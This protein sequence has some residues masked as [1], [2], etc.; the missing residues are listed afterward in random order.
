MEL[1]TVRKATFNGGA[2]ELTQ[3]VPQVIDQTRA[4]IQYAETMIYISESSLDASASPTALSSSHQHSHETDYVS[5][6]IR[7]DRDLLDLISMLHTLI[8][9]LPSPGLPHLVVESTSRVRKGLKVLAYYAKVG[10]LL[11]L[12]CG[13]R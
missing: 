6:I 10:A 3:L 12:R 8:L 4:A 7:S 5:Q 1:W 9:R 11:L 13:Y 2:H